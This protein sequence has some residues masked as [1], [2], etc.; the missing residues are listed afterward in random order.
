MGKINSRSGIF[1]LLF[2]VLAVLPATRGFAQ[3]SKVDSQLKWLTSTKGWA[4]KKSIEVSIDHPSS[5]ITNQYSPCVRSGI[6]T[7]KADGTYAEVFPK[8]DCPDQIIE[9]AKGT[10]KYFSSAQ[11]HN[12]IAR[13]ELHDSQIDHYY[14]SLQILSFNE[15]TLMGWLN[16]TH[17]NPSENLF[18]FRLNGAP[19][20]LQGSN[21]T[22]ESIKPANDQSDKSKANANKSNDLSDIKGYALLGKIYS[23]TEISSANTANGAMYMTKEEQAIYLYCNLA[24]LYPQKFNQL[25]KDYVASVEDYRKSGFLS[26]SYYKSLISDMNRQKPVQALY[27]DKVSYEFAKCWAEESGQK[28]IIGHDRIT[29]ADNNGGENCSYG[30]DKAIDIVAQLMVDDGTESLGHRKNILMDKYS[31][32]GVSIRPHKQYGNCAV[33]DFGYRT[34]REREEAASRKAEF[35][36]QLAQYSTEERKKA[37]ACRTLSYLNDYE[38]DF[39]FYVNLIRINPAK[40]QSLAWKDAPLFQIVSTDETEKKE[41]QKRYNELRTWF[42]Q[43]AAVKVMIPTQQAV[44][45]GRCMTKRFISDQAN[46]EG[47]LKSARGWVVSYELPDDYYNDIMNMFLT[48]ETFERFLVS[49]NLALIMEK[50]N[51]KYCK[52]LLY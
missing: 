19:D 34:D 24:R 9:D 51:D 30:F 29:C 41:K 44:S 8:K 47:C 40:F 14:R 7:F 12:G 21:N 48:Y 5:D 49:D 17:Q 4:F 15:T 6:I 33:Q 43:L 50:A 25:M 27:P 1:S 31:G 10:W 37:D 39:Y 52:L 20:H 16:V 46:P 11:F 2:I 22:N 45:E 36:K 26:S 38:K 13:I 28:G 32:L 42:G 23:Q 35:Q 18:V 3:V